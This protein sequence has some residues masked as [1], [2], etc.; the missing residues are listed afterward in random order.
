MVPNAVVFNLETEPAN[1]HPRPRHP[2]QYAA[3]KIAERRVER[4]LT[5][6]QI[7]KTK[8]TTDEDFHNP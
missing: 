8:A 4:A 6:H 5:N 1:S 2:A 7:T 3:T